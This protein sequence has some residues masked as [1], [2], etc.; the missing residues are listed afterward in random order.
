MDPALPLHPLRAPSLWTACGVGLFALG[1]ALRGPAGPAAATLAMREQVRTA[2]GV[3][4]SY[5][6][7][8]EAGAARLIL[9]H[10]AP[11]CAT[12]W[13]DYLVDPP[14]DAE[15]V[16]LDRPGFGD[17]GPEAALPRLAD[18]AA[19]V[20][21]LM[22]SDARRVVL[23]GHSLG[24]AVAARVSADLPERVSALV[25]LAAALDPSLETIHPMQHL[26]AWA[27]VRAMLPRVLR[28]TN[29]ELM[30]LRSELEALA[31]DLPRITARVLIVHG[32]R[33]DL[34]PVANVR[35]MQ[36]RLMSAR[37]VRTT[38]LEGRNHFLPWNSQA[39]VRRAMRQALSSEEGPAC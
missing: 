7:A 2:A 35:Y 15:V 29:A 30:M 20:Q 3:S 31:Q 13:A 27:P 39:E 36:S 18:Q 26:G 28:N 23:V 12:S 25:L 8:G 14:A 21:A 6:L 33:D 38:L 1:R 32:T 16:A 10:G 11:G 34:V 24:G 4:L 37:C 22:P 17:S 5:L 9:V 19:A